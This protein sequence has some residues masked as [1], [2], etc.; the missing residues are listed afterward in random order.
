MATFF[1]NTKY[2]LLKNIGKLACPSLLH[3]HSTS[4]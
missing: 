1:Y 4:I 2:H 3:K